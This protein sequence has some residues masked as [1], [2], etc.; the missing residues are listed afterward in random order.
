MPSALSGDLDVTELCVAVVIQWTAFGETRRAVIV[1]QCPFAT[2]SGLSAPIPPDC[3]RSTAGANR[4]AIS[5]QK[6]LLRS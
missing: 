5:S 3:P 6:S 2:T 1:N 4:R